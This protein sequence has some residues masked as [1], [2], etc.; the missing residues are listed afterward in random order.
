M[1]GCK[2]FRRDLRKDQDDE[3]QHPSGDRD[4]CIT[5]QANS[6]YRGNGRRENIDKVIAN[7]NKSN[8]TIGTIQQREDPFGLGRS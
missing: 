2:G 4:T 8:Q 3:G 1:Q 6:Q 7:Q 5:K